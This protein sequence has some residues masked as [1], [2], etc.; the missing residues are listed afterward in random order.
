MVWPC[1]LSRCALSRCA[2]V[3]RAKVT[4]Y[5]RCFRLSS[6]IALGQDLVPFVRKYHGYAISF[7]T[8]YNF[9]Y[10]PMEGSPGFVLGYL[11]QVSPPTLNPKP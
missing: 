4:S 5:I 10:H 2:P 8:T 9:W 6:N 3:T 11:Y 1:L 7:G